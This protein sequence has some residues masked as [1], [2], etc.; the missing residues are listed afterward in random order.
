[1]GRVDTDVVDI[2]CNLFTRPALEEF[3]NSQG[4]S[5]AAELFNRPEMY[6]PSTAMTATEFVEKMDREGVDQV[7][8]PALQFGD[9]DGGMEMD[10]SYEEVRSVCTEYPDRIKGMAGINPRE[11]MDGVAKL[12]RYVEDHGFI[13]GHLEPY[14]WDRPLNHRQFYPFYAKCAELDVPVV[15]QV[16]HSAVR[17]PSRM[18][19][20]I[21]VDDLAIDFPELDIVA[22]HTGWP[23]SKVLEAIAWKHPNVYLGATAHAPKYWE[24]NITDFIRG[25]GQDKSMFGT[26]YPV[27]DYPEVFD[28]IDGMEF[29]ADV[30]RKLLGEN[31]RSVFGT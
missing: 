15:M 30:E 11:G 14:G 4:Q 24:E 7:Y 5:V 3:Y 16:G 27:L 13:A 20:P 31:A 18:G 17:M 22:C 9:P 29:D 21:L 28:Q 25:R 2:W 10:I 6:D 1:M 12:E 23:W 8:V 26:D 19:K